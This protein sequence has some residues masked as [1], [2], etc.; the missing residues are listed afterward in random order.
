MKTYIL[1]FPRCLNLAFLKYLGLFSIHRLECSFIAAGK[2][3]ALRFKHA[4]DN[5]AK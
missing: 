3:A 1:V 5:W 2:K 4:S